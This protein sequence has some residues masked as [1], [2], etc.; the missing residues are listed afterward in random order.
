M[1]N[2]SYLRW[3]ANDT[4]T[5][6]WHDSADPD[7]LDRGLAQGAC[8]V[9]TNPVLTHRALLARPAF[10]RERVGPLEPD[11]DPST[12]AERL[13]QAVIT[14]AARKLEPQHQAS[15]G[16]VGY[17]CAQV[18]PALAGDREAMLAMARRFHAWAPNIAVKLPVTAAGLDVLEECVAEGT[19]ITAT[20][21]FTVPQV[22]AVAERHRQG[23]ARARAKGI[24]PGHCFAV[25]MIGRIDDYLRDVAWDNRVDVS[26][27]DIRQAGLA[28]SKRAHGIF[29]AEGYE[30]VLLVAALRGTYHMTE[31]AGGE[32]IM[33]IHPRYQEQLLA[34]GVPRE[35]RIGRPIDPQVIARLE[36]ISEFVRAYEPDGMTPEEFVAY[37][38][39]QRTLSQFSEIG[40][41]MLEAFD[42]S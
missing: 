36:H 35:E 18:N 8:G 5:P 3:L 4:P 28:I 33:S 23:A 32:L 37:G 34:P 29:Q 24:V 9:T 20:M 39:T 42:A 21:S 25:I 38:V 40:W 13:M 10:W 22:V 26:E 15:N 6:W 19:T 16:A 31:L 7:E 2:D 17:V 11:L 14:A 30:A 41:A 12:K 27:P 1:D